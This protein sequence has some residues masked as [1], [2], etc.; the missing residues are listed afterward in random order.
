MPE[1]S[2]KLHEYS[3]LLQHS[4]AV[5]SSAR[6]DKSLPPGQLAEL[7]AIYYNAF[8]GAMRSGV[9]Y[10]KSMD[11]DGYPKFEIFLD[12]IRYSC[13]DIAVRDILQESY[14]KVAGFPFEDTSK[15]YVQS[16]RALE[17]LCAG[18]G[19]GSE[20][21]S[22]K[23]EELARMSAEEKAKFQKKLE[24]AEQEKKEALLNERRKRLLRDARGFDY[25]PNYDH[26]YSDRLPEI[27][28]K[29]DSHAA[30]YAARII[31]IAIS[32]AGI[33]F[34]CMFL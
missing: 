29:L 27:L 17:A 10:K 33:A 16:Y 30:D 8:V 22:A 6:S 11:A 34:S 7:Y 23:A 5:I 21:A 15:S 1:L 12:N 32:V 13:K 24:Q 25:D 19:A 31:C 2:E 3:N 28:K 20:T 14:E 18:G 4:A 26:Y 9:M